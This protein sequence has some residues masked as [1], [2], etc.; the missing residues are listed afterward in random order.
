MQNIFFLLNCAQKKR[1]GNEDLY[2]I[3]YYCVLREVT[4]LDVS[5]LFYLQIINN[6]RKLNQM[7]F[8]G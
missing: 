1:T 5:H 4:N 8:K 2:K 3:L 6:R 7:N